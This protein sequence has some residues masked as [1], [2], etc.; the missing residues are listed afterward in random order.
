[1]PFELKNASARFQRYEMFE[2]LIITGLILVHIDDFLIA[3]KIAEEHLE[4][5]DR[6]IKILVE[7]KLELRL[8]KCRFMYE[9]IEFLGYKISE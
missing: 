3:T 9:E 6:V 8:N 1:M 2:P 7:N 5:L 4:A